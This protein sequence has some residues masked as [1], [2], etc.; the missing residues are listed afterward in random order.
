[1]ANFILLK[2]SI[3]LGV[4]NLLFVFYYN[5]VTSFKICIII[6]VLTSILNHGLTNDYLKYFDRIAMIYGIIV[7]VKLLSI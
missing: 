7:E 5:S 4:L 3:I 2:S 1:M 6:G